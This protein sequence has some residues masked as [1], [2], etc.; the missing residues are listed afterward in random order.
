MLGLD[1]TDFAWSGSRIPAASHRVEYRL[2]DRL[3]ARVDLSIASPHK[4]TA[5][6]SIR[7]VAIG[8]RSLLLY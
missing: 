6:D 5:D 7:R 1:S 4:R 2:L 8:S 3:D